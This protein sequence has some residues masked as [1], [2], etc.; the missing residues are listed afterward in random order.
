M[1]TITKN[2][3]TDLFLTNIPQ[4]SSF[5]DLRNSSLEFLKKNGLPHLKEEEYKFTQISKKL[6]QNITAFTPSKNISISS[7]DVKSNLFE[8]FDGDVIV[9]NNGLLDTQL[10]SISS[11]NYSFSKLSDSKSELL[12]NI[13]TFESDPFTALNNIGFEDGLHIQTAKGKK[14]EKPIAFLLFNQANEGQIIQPRILI[15][16]AENSDVTFIENTISADEEAYFSNAVVEVKVAQN[17][18]AYY[19]RLQNENRK[20]ISVTNFATDIHRDATFTSVALQ[21]QADMLR[22]NL[23]LNLLDKGCVGNMY[24]LY[25]L[26]GKTHVDNHT[27]VDHTK[28]N[29]DSNELYKGILTDSSR[30]VFN[31]KIFVRQDAQKTNAFQ[32]NNNILLSENAIINTKPQLEIWADDVKC[33]HG[34]TTGQLDEEALFYLQARGI[35]KEQARGLLLYAVAGEVLEHIAY[36]PFRSYCI[37]LIEE[38]LGSNF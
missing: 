24:G 12:G 23:T 29:S 22:N 6:E 2:K 1:T 10:S 28:P 21:L 19:Y 3:L 32:Q 36:E 7:S 4:Y 30:G 31:G 35:G 9:F 11:K 37:Q 13:A 5:E 17:S 8:G 14:V 25:L 20:A 26:N 27:N 33:S 18:H 16:V 38:R 15:E 34:C